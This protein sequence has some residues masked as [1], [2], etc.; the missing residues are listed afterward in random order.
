MR[1][2]PKDK[3]HQNKG[4]TQMNWIARKTKNPAC[5]KRGGLQMR[6]HIGA[7]T[8]HFNNGKAHHT[9]PTLTKA[10]PFKDCACKKRVHNQRKPNTCGKT[11]KPHWE[12]INPFRFT[13]LINGRRLVTLD[14]IGRL[15]IW[16]IWENTLLSQA[17]GQALVAILPKR[18]LMQGQ[19]SLLQGAA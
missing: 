15:A 1:L 19:K 5:H 16:N 10:P 11:R 6:D 7:M 17:A 2:P 8:G 12:Q 14:D 4:I 9:T 13:K 3:S 18:L